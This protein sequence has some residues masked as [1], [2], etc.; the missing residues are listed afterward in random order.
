MSDRPSRRRS[1]RCRSMPGSGRRTPAPSRGRSERHTWTRSSEPTSSSGSSG[2][3]TVGDTIEEYERA[4]K[5]RKPILVY[6]KDVD[7][8]ARDPQ[9]RDFLERIGRL[10]GDTAPG[11]FKTVPALEE[12]L[13]NDVPRLLQ[14]VVRGA[15]ARRRPEW[16]CPSTPSGR[17]NAA[18]SSRGFESGSCRASQRSATLHLRSPRRHGRAWEDLTRLRVRRRSRRWQARMPTASWGP[19]SA[20]SRTCCGACPTRDW[21]SR[22]SSRRRSIRDEQRWPAVV[23]AAVRRR[24]SARNR[25]RLERRPAQAVPRRRPRCLHLVTTRHRDVAEAAGAEVLEVDAMTMAETLALTARGPG[26]SPMATWRPL[27]GS[28]ARSGYCRSR[29]SC[30]PRRPRPWVG[31]S[32][33]QRGS[34]GGSNSCAAGATPRAGRTRS[35]IPSR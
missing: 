34:P 4:R 26:R 10:D 6:E 27:P 13:K 2:A 3:N 21:G 19:S 8:G 31:R 28:R 33:G 30:S 25:R 20:P 14:Q 15:A 12:R 5:L 1:R 17:S 32:F 18:R 16:R 22:T 9:L 35:P 29:S 11:R 7:V 23:D 24:L